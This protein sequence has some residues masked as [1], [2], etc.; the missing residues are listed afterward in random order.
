MKKVNFNQL[1]NVKTP[2]SWIENA[3]N[4]PQR[5][6]KPIPFYLRPYFIA[7]AASVVLC[8][9]LSL[10]VFANL[11]NDVSVL[12]VS[13]PTDSIT[14]TQ[15][16][17]NTL[18]SNAD[19]P[20]QA[21]TGNGIAQGATDPFGNLIFLQPVT[22]PNETNTSQNN[23]GSK[24]NL[25]AAT[26]PSSNGNTNHSKPY[27]P[28]TGLNTDPPEEP[29]TAKPTSVP[30]VKPTQKPTQS[31]TSMPLDVE[32]VTNFTEPTPDTMP[33]TYDICFLPSRNTDFNLSGNVYCHIESKNGF[34][35]T[36]SFTDNELCTRKGSGSSIRFLYNPS[37]KY[38]VCVDD[39]YIEM[40]NYYVTFYDDSGHSITRLCYL[41]YGSYIFKE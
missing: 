26:Q 1:K 9:A 41:G 11:G 32:E 17:S 14:S 13:N 7:S 4:I 19:S 31:L 22:E 20:S 21:I 37:E 5:N 36:E 12:P 15:N 29:V 23:S 6:K 33:F 18:D 40:G 24:G 8:C 28:T 39:D 34:E 16:L 10:F 38:G 3:I 27:T 30:S 25:G 35:Y 2:E